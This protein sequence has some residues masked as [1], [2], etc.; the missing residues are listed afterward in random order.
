MDLGASPKRFYKETSVCAL[1]GGWGVMLDRF[2]LRT[3]AK[4]VLT[5]P[6]EALAVLISA[7][8]ASQGE[9][10]SPVTMPVT[11]LANL[12]QDR[13]QATHT[14]LVNE[15]VA[16]AGADLICYRTPTPAGLA[17]QQAAHW[18]PML[19]WAEA[20]F[21]ARLLTTDTIARI[22]QPPTALTAIEARAAQLDHW[23]LTGVAFVTG[24]TGSAVIGLMMQAGA[25]GADDALAAIRI[26]EDWNATIWGRDDEE[27][28]QAASRRVDLGAA[29]AYFGA[30]A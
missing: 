28:A 16:Y 19:D 29:A 3:P 21:G 14:D 4:S 7:E 26:E 22:E 1:D 24:L 2:A 8:W 13:G 15:V 10:I 20:T 30:L 25:L 9:V 23:A 18:D 17:G 12:A 5:V 11:R 6:T 27:A